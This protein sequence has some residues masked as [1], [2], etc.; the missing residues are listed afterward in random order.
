[1]I[2]PIIRYRIRSHRDGTFVVTKLEDYEPVRIYNISLSPDYC[3]CPGFNHHK[4]RCKHIK[5][6]SIY[7]NRGRPD[8][9]WELWKNG[10]VTMDPLLSVEA[11]V[12]NSYFGE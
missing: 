5:L 6:V 9:L 2:N 12:T 8:A 4:I 7:N 10:T 11:M 3:E 1:M